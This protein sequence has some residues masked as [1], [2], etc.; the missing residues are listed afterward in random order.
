VVAF[1]PETGEA[2]RVAGS[3]EGWARAVLDDHELL[4]GYPL[5][6]RW[7]VERGPIPAGSRLVAKVPFACG[8]DFEIENLALLGAV[9]G[10]RARAQIANQLREL[11]D[12][13]RISFRITD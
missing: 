5:A 10:M 7:Q 11:P 8:G 9:E 6:H 4:T 1:D 2:T 13:A 12:G 3:L